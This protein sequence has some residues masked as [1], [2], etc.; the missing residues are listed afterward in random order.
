M[1]YSK[2]ASKLLSYYSLHNQTETTITELAAVFQCSERHTKTIIHYL[3]DEQWITWQVS[4]GRGRKPIITLHFKNDDILLER[5]K[6]LVQKKNYQKSFTVIHQASNAYQEAFRI[7]FQQQLGITQVQ[8]DKEKHL[9]VLRYPFYPVSLCLDP[10]HAKSRHD[11]HM[12]QQIF[13]CLLTYHSETNTLEPRIAHYWESK[14]GKQW[15]FYLRKNVPFHHGRMVDA[16]DIKSTLLRF[17]KEHIFRIN[18]RNIEIINSTTLIFHL[19]KIDYL[20]PR[21]LADIRSA[22]VPIDVIENSGENF[23]TK[24]VGSGPFQLTSYNDKRIQ[25]DRFENYYG[26]SPWLDRVEIITTPEKF[27][28]DHKHPLLLK[29]PNSSWKANHTYQQGANFITF[30]CRK[31]GPLQNIDYRKR[32]CKVIHPADFCLIKNGEIAAHSMLVE[33][34]LTFSNKI[35]RI[36][37]NLSS[38][39]TLKI[40]VQQIREG[41]NHYREAV[42]L[43]QLL[44]QNGIPTDMELIDI[45]ELR[46]PDKLMNYDLIVGGI[47][48]STDRLL[49]VLTF[50]ES[51]SMPLYPLLPD[52]AQKE[53][54]KHISRVRHSQ[55]FQNQWDIYYQLENYLKEQGFIT[56]L[57]HRSHTVY[58]PENSLYENIQLDHN[59]RIDYRKVWKR[60][61]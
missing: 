19:N 50:M 9:D 27:L 42:I 24:P 34:S 58:E 40:A 53:V 8:V 49:S 37:G 33:K 16:N 28:P 6:E 14:N 32:L 10:L 13:E 41:A 4:R 38:T 51:M 57:N 31:K 54:K 55:D 47:F 21:L 1:R 20:F 35:N 23:S 15:I 17:N 43:Q 22:I 46:N 11:T 29:A 12:I 36:A 3:M 60:A 59:G 18:I 44:L 25:L 26:L 2:Y 30:N 48:L 52:N 7:W 61:F 56:F 39:V 5:A 45:T